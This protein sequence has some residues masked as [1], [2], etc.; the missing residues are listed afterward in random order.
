[1]KQRIKKIFQLKKIHS[2]NLAVGDVQRTMITSFSIPILERC[3]ILLGSA[4]ISS[5]N[6][7]GGGNRRTS[8]HPHGF[9]FF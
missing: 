7:G 9:L 3:R 2:G 6:E 8:N 1:M 4:P 5:I